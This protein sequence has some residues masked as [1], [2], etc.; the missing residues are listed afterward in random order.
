MPRLSI[1]WCKNCGHKVGLH[2]KYGRWAHFGV[3]RG[4]N[5]STECWAYAGSTNTSLDLGAFRQASRV[6]S[7]CT[8]LKPDPDPTKPFQSKWVLV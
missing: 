7:K 8:C 6:G 1:G 2:P 4:Y 3:G 5:L